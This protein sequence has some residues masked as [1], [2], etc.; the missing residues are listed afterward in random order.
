MNSQEKDTEIFK[1][2][3]TDT[4]KLTEKQAILYSG[5][6]IFKYQ[7]K[8]VKTKEVT[9]VNYACRTIFKKRERK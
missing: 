5:D 2:K 4:V 8:K 7:K 6:C 9:S 1:L 3:E